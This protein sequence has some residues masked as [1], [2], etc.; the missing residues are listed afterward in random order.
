MFTYYVFA[1]GATLS[2]YLTM[3]DYLAK[4]E[5]EKGFVVFDRVSGVATLGL[6]L[7]DDGDLHPPVELSQ[8]TCHLGAGDIDADSLD[9]PFELQDALFM[10]LLRC[11]LIQTKNLAAERAE[12]A[13]RLG[14][15]LVEGKTRVDN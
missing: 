9:Q 1:Y 8:Y 10:S 14:I 5:I 4:R 11:D 3:A 13:K 15:Q 12:Y 7:H 2:D 6:K